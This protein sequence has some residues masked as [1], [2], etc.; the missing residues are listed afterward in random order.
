MGWRQGWQDNPD[1][2][3]GWQRLARAYDV[4]GRTDAAQDAFVSAADVLVA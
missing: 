2:G 1:D 3:P 4:L